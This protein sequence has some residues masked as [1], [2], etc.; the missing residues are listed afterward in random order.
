MGSRELN[1][2]VLESQAVSAQV[3]NH[4]KTCPNMLRGV[5]SY[6]NTKVHLIK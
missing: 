1:I 2:M 5:I 6:L 3:T 4:F